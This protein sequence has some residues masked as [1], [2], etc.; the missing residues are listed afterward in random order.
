MPKP[1]YN[2]ISSFWA[3][4]VPAFLLGLIYYAYSATGWLGASIRRFL[5]PIPNPLADFARTLF[6]NLF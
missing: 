6:N 2:P 1:R 4:L 3:F 5:N